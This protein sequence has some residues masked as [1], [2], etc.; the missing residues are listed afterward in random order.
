MECHAMNPRVV[1]FAR[2]YLLFA[3]ALT[4]SGGFGL[5]A[6]Y[7]QGRVEIEA[8]AGVPFGVGRITVQSGGEFKI[9]RIPRAGGAR[10]GRILDLAK[11][12]IDQSGKESPT[13]LQSAEMTLWEKSGRVLYPV[14]E[15]RDRPILREFVTVPASTTILFLFSGNAPLDVTVQ[16]P[17]AR[18]GQVTPQ[19]D[20]N[21]HARLLRAWWRD[22]ASAA[23][24]RDVTREYPPMVEEYLV[25][26]LARRLQLT[27]PKHATR[28]DLG[29]FRS[30]L[31]LLLE[32][33][34]AHLEMAEAILLGG[35]ASQAA[36]QNLPE[37]L[38][39]P[40]PESLDP[41]PDTP[42]EPIA[43]RVPVECLYVRFG[44]FPNFL[45]LRHRLEDWGGELRDIVAERGLSYGLNERFQRQL[46]LRESA[47]AELLGEKV[48]AD[49]AVIGT[50]TFLHE[51]AALGM[52]FHA[53]SNTALSADLT[54][55]RTTAMKEDKRGTQEKL[56]IAG[57]QVSLI[58]TPDNALRSF[59]VADGDFHLVTTSR[60]LVEWFLATGDGT[61]DSLG[62]SAEFRYAR[63]NVPLARGDTV[64]VY[65]APQFFQNLLS[66]SYR[67]E[68]DRRLRSTV[69]MELLDIAQLAAR[70]EQKPG[71][72]ID[73]LVAG[74][75]LPEG[76]GQR[77]DGSR[78]ELAEGRVVDSLR[79]GRGTFVPVPDVELGK[80]T[81]TE[82]A[83]YE[84][85]AKEYAAQ[86][87][88]MDP[89]V[90]AI[91]RQ[92]LAE[93]GLERVI[94]DVQAAPLSQKHVETLSKWLGEPTDQRL[95]PVPGDIVVFEAVMRGG[96]FF[97]DGE[98]HLFGALRDADP[99]ITLD[100]S[101]GILA[102]LLTSRLEGLQG[103]LG[104]WPNPGFLKFLGGASDIPP[105]PAGLSR[106]RTGL[107][108]RQVESFT[109]LSFHPEILQQVSPQL[110]FV[111]AE[112]PAQAWLRAEDLAKS[113]LAPLV[114]AF[115][116]RKSRQITLGNTRLMN[117]LS[118]QLHV[119]Q[120][121]CL[122]TGQRL[123]NAQF[124]APLGGKYELREWEGGL[125]TWVS[126]ALADRTDST[127]PPED[128]QF[129]ALTWLRGIDLELSTQNG[130]LA[131]HG[132]VIMPV[133][134][135]AATFQ[136][137][138]FPFAGPKAGT[139]E[140][141]NGN[142]KSNGPAKAA[143]KRP[144]LPG[145]SDARRSGTKEF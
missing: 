3:A 95:A 65:L 92:P 138:A 144:A 70:A 79:G 88:P 122:A 39:Q 53:K 131:A 17:E 25:D 104:A 20:P 105:D 99:A 78:L 60:T 86:W 102:R 97:A 50:D 18:A 139:S 140:K 77:P 109:L 6:C 13:H 30:E 91:Q 110:Q 44:N 34:A 107:W 28:A 137:P 130:M 26:T 85:F 84:R 136:L 126:S 120:A 111:K 51:G 7:A 57:R 66:A 16:T 113:K 80:I 43:M 4:V 101:A 90:A 115:G 38:P 49:V 74:G 14:F 134:T 12:L 46:G 132:E 89:L 31:N 35:R 129:P 67:I 108:R 128:Y 32:T 9:N 33:E 124:E 21:G 59:Y 1:R 96:S 10:G 76:F 123:L 127:Q 142:S 117:M 42:I 52:L 116:Y 83:E 82:L 61:H 121:E 75:L 125:K 63:R 24:G 72:T 68:L 23:E 119:P 103:Y 143:P 71:A 87:G 27:V 19:Q 100:P 8:F 106:L 36:T 5:P 133:E 41:I 40:K 56:T 69:E 55:Q 37:E 114:N 45:W 54:Q 94:V 135:R 141:A 64:F 98:H 62:A 2:R 47:L 48:I 118:E 73:Q 81:P 112:R 15:K 58:S 11:K 145:P 29:L 22:Y 93:G